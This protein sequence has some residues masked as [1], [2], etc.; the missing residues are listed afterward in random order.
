MGTTNDRVAS[1]PLRAS[2]VLTELRATLAA[3]GYTA[4][5]VVDPQRLHRFLAGTGAA[6]VSGLDERL[7]AIV[8]LFALNE[9]LPVGEA[10]EALAP[11]DLGEIG[12]TGVLSVDGDWAVPNYRLVPHGQ[13]LIAGDGRR[14]A[15]AG[16]NVVSTFTGPSL[17]LARLVPQTPVGAMLDVG[18]GSGILAL[19]GAEHSE[20][21]TALD[22]NPR[23]LE[24]AQFN[25][26]LNAISNVEVLEGSWF[27]PVAGRRFDLIVINPPYIV[28]P[29]N[30]LA[31]RD[32]GLR[33]TALLDQLV[34][35]A[36]AH[37]ESGGLAL[38]LCSWPHQSEDDW[39]APPTSAAA[40]TACDAL[41]I[42]HSTV[43]PL[44]YAAGWNTPPVSFAEPGKVRE[45]VARWIEY[46]REIGAGALSYGEIVLRR[47]VSGAPWI[48]ALRARSDT[49]ER[50]TEH[51]GRL[52]AGHDL[53]ERLDDRALLATRFSLPDGIDVSQRFQRRDQRFVARPAM[54]RFDDGLGL[55]APVDPDV[56]D[57]LFACDGRKTLGELVERAAG[58]PGTD[59]DAAREDAAETL[60]ELL[61]Y[62]LL[63]V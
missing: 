3:A 33:G 45:A 16:A 42:C 52:L 10:S 15:G 39:A 38:M 57:V 50:A 53:A 22:V 29:D 24:F 34:R 1:P 18:T 49:G 4:E 2:P 30:E 59:L 48:Q 26:R 31:Y 20:H 54:I 13:L 63:E 35:D 11:V 32:S 60:R 19:L 41:I 7:S 40:G 47:R 14:G 27:E 61:T 46:Y 21:V 43:D 17:K 62:G 28:S 51:L 6:A 23:A 5:V 36:A 8:R 37:L 9:P 25:A 12:E 55:S 58:R 44:D 56:L